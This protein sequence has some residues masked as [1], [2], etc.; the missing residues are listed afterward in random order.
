MNK[1][2]MNTDEHF[3]SDKPLIHQPYPFYLHL[4]VVN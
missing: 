3:I 1:P 2:Q 4:S